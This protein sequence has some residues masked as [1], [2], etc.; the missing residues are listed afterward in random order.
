MQ[1]HHITFEKLDFGWNEKE[2]SEE[3]CATAL[4]SLKP[5]RPEKE[6]LVQEKS[7]V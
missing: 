2:L 3:E 6:H 4:Q 7:L 5:E 1:Q